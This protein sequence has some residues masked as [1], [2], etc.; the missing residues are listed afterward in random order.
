MLL[1]LPSRGWRRWRMEPHRRLLPLL[2]PCLQTLQ[3][4]SPLPRRK[5]SQ[6]RTLARRSSGSKTPS[7]IPHLRLPKRV[8]SQQPLRQKMTRTLAACTIAHLQVQASQNYAD[9]R[10]MPS[11]SSQS[12]CCWQDSCDEPENEEVASSAEE[13]HVY[14]KGLCEKIVACRP[15]FFNK[16]GRNP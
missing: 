16:C 7:P 6:P 13:V 3:L 15:C 14:I 5:M 1:R 8:R 2:Q 10:P 12:L 9:V 4:E 11:A